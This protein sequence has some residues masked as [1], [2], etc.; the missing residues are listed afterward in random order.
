MATHHFDASIPR[1]A[2]LGTALRLGV[3]GVAGAIAVDLCTPAASAATQDN[4]RRCAKCNMMFFNGFRKSRCPAGGR[5]QARVGANFVLP[6]DGRETPTA[7]AGWRFCNKCE[8]LFYDGFPNKGVCPGKGGHFAMGYNFVLPHDLKP[9][10][11]YAEKDWRFCTKCHAMFFDGE[12]RKG[13]CAAGGE[14]AAMG[15]NFVLSFRGNLQDDNV[16]IPAPR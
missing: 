15:F 12:A 11:A 16:G 14:H 7:Q 5:H 2:F 8:S 6:Y 3:T 13:P 4:W 1:R 10:S 9:R